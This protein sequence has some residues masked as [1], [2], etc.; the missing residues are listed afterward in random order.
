MN[1]TA[2]EWTD[3]TWNPIVGC[4]NDCPYCYA[5]KI[6]ER[7]NKIHSFADPRF[8]E[9]RLNE[10][11]T[12]KKPSRIFV[13]SM[14]DL[15]APWISCQWQ[16]KI[17][18]TIDRCKHHTFMFLSKFPQ[19]YPCTLPDNIWVGTTIESDTAKAR[20]ESLVNNKNRKF[21]SIEPILGYCDTADLSRIDQII[22]GTLTGAS[23][24]KMAY[25]LPL[26]Y[27]IASVKHHQV[28][29][30]DSIR[31]LFPEFENHSTPFCEQ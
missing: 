10:P 30:K 12:I 20:I 23:W 9:E 31:K 24:E 16:E 28:F 26:Y 13:G 29:Y 4:K 2:I 15:F 14:C 7:F 6:H 27:W 5:R 22:I 25:P 3:F 17:I 11:Y 21:I 18:D 8:F 19:Y 1:R